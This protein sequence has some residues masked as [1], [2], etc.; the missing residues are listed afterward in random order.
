M[1][2]WQPIS[3]NAALKWDGG[4]RASGL[5]IYG[6]ITWETI[7]GVGL[8][9][10]DPNWPTARIEQDQA[11]HPS[12]IEDTYSDETDQVVLG[13]DLRDRQGRSPDE[14]Y[15]DVAE[16]YRAAKYLTGQPV[17]MICDQASVPKSTAKFWVRECRSRGY[18]PATTRGRA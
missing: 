12:E 7:Q 10:A 18:L 6:H 16:F 17:R 8:S 11:P 13:H 5:V 15:A 3:P 1:A 2:Y 9:K 14:F 4:S